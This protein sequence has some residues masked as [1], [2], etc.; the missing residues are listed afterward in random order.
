MGVL[1]GRP[2][3]TNLAAGWPSGTAGDLLS[4][5]MVWALGAAVAVKVAATLV[6]LYDRISEEEQETSHD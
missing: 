6:G 2:F 5:G 4:A 3:L 1:A